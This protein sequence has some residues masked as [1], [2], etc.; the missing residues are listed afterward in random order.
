MPL[1]RRRFLFGT[2]ALATTVA[3]LSACN[4]SAGSDTGDSGAAPSAA[5]G[6]E[7]GAY[8]VTISHKYGETTITAAPQ[9]VVTVGLKEQDDCIAL[10]VVPVGSTTWFDL[11]GS[12]LFGPWAKDALGGAAE[13]T[14]LTDTDG[15]QFEQVAALDP[16]LIIG[17]YSG[18]K[19]ADY[20]KLTA[21]APTIA[22]LEKYQ[23][24]GVPWDAEAA[25]VGQALGRPQQMTGLIEDAKKRVQVVR[26]SN[27]EFGGRTALAATPWEGVFVYGSQDPRGRLLTDLGFSMPPA[28]DKTIEDAWGGDLSDEN[29]ELLDVD[30]LVWLVEGEG[31]KTVEANKAYASLAV[32]KEGREVFTAPG[33]G[34]YEAF[35]FL[36]VLSIGYLVEELAPRL[37]NAVDGDP[38]TSADKS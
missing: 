18:M 5:G 28:L 19:P 8:P 26:E 3:G 30:A 11:E 16:D 22:P 35:S 17:V 6:V 23:D 20:E 31:R 33:D 7:E 32:H 21:L 36:T 4:A 37:K 12:K 15:I 29:V 9:R 10:G 25:V 38:S 13:P 27:P 34:M 2:A 24:W 14:V 1:S